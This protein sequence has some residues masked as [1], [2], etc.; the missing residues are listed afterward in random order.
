M[1]DLNKFKNE[2]NLSGQNVYVGHRYVPKIFGEWDNA[3]IYEPLSIVQY[4]GTSYTSRQYVPVGI[5]ITNEDFWVVTG[6]YN[7]QI[8]QY[9][10]DVRNLENDLTTFN[11]EVINARNGELT[12]NARLDK[13][14][15][16][17]NAQL[18]NIAVNVK[19]FGAIGDGQTNDTQ[20]F[21]LA[22]EEINSL[23]G[24]TLFVP[25]G[26]Y[27]IDDNGVKACDNLTIDMSNGVTLKHKPSNERE[28]RTINIEN[29]NMLKYWVGS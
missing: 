29:V 5:E 20:A 10:Q 22:I 25:K 13:D 18:K 11:D 12:L 21:N 27:L 7:A 1:Q 16:E 15:Q 4:Q 3:N 14:N 17:L 23:G 8:E 19:N 9:R 24:G 26:T 28:Y 6:N 2:M